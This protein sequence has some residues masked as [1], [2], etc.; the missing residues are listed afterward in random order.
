[1]TQ[2]Q[3]AMVTGI[4]DR[5]EVLCRGLLKNPFDEGFD[6]LDSIINQP[7]MNETC[8]KDWPGDAL[9]KLRAF[10]QD[11]VQ[12][13]NLE[14]H[15]AH[16]SQ[17]LEGPPDFDMHAARQ[18][19]RLSLLLLV[20]SALA[21]LDRSSVQLAKLDHSLMTFFLMADIPRLTASVPQVAL[22]CLLTCAPFSEGA[23]REQAKRQL[24]ALTQTLHFVKT[25][26]AMESFMR[27]LFFCVW[28]QRE[29]CAALWHESHDASS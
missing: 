8:I 5:S 12:M 1:M 6:I 24:S 9:T 16:A 20:N 4:P 17:A 22:F 3:Q 11:L 14:G 26:E 15:A 10:E 7:R 27:P 21:C 29:K 25:T 28:L 13:G 18:A 19:L 23:L 2:P